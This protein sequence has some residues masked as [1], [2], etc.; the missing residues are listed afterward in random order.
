MFRTHACPESNAVELITNLAP[1]TITNAGKLRR[2]KTP[3]RDYNN[4]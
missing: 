1:D 4:P 3:E 2:H